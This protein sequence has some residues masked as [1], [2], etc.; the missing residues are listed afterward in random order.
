MA[1]AV[2]S[3]EKIKAFY[4]SQVHDPDK[5]DLNKV[6]LYSSPFLF[7]LSRFHY[8]QFFYFLLICYCICLEID[9]DICQ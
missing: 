2:I 8:Y 1:D 7:L 5:W 4:H 6:I 3:V 9:Y